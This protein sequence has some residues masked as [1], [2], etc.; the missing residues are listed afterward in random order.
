[1]GAKL[2]KE[3]ARVVAT[4]ETVGRMYFSARSRKG[5]NGLQDKSMITKFSNC[6]GPP[7]IVLAG[8]N[9]NICGFYAPC[10]LTPQPQDASPSPSIIRSMRHFQIVAHK[11]RGAG[12]SSEVMVGGEQRRRHQATSAEIDHRSRGHRSRC[13]LAPP[14]SRESASF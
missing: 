14:N 11:G 9:R 3:A 1:M 6:N 12:W 10:S 5:R 2:Q 13:T 8:S 4:R 7:T